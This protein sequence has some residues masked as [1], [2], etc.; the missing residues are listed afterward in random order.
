MEA[1][2]PDGLVMRDLEECDYNKGYLRL[3]AQLTT[4]GDVSAAQFKARFAELAQRR[5]DYRIVVIED[6][7]SGQVVATGTVLMELK[8]IHSCGKVAHIEDIVVDDGARGKHLGKRIISELSRIAKEAGCYKVILDCA[9]KNI[10]FY[11]KCG[12]EVKNTGMA[13]YFS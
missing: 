12:Y 1:P 7:S 4:A 5:A 3:L 8:F 10:P 9:E 2:L 6:T 13:L 11:E